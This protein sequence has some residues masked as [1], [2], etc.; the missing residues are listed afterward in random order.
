MKLSDILTNISGFAAIAIIIAG[1]AGF[2]AVIIAA[3]IGK[4][5]TPEAMALVDRFVNILVGLA[6]GAGAGGSALAVRAMRT[7]EL[8]SLALNRP[9]PPSMQGSVRSEGIAQ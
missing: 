4:P 8:Q 5:L 2:A 3:I 1:V 6:V 7:M 9:Q